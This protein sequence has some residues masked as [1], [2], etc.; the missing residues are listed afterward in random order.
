MNKNLLESLQQAIITYAAEDAGKLSAEIVKQGI[1][2]LEALD[3]MT[4]AI[5]QVGDGFNRG[6]LWLPD[7]IRASEAFKA[8]LPPLTEELAR[9]GT[10]RRDAGVVV[11]GTVFGDIHNIG[12]DMVATLLAADGFAV[13]DLGINVTAERFI[14]AV[15]EHH[16]DL[17]AMSALLSITAQEQKKVIAALR[18][19]G[20]RETVKV[21]VGGGAISQEFAET[22]GADGYAATAPLATA[23]ARSLIDKR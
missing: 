3:R 18:R 20:L 22:I 11:I 7:L 8:A 5:R 2:P 21:I 9:R 17:L 12:K 4:L 15:K 23:L 13:H 19:E 16:A 14:A 1:D 10:V 6:D